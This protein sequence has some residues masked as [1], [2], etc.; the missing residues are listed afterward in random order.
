MTVTT[1]IVVQFS[2]GA[3]GGSLSAEIDS[4]EDGLNLGKSNFLPGDSASFLVFRSPDVT[5]DLV[6][7]SAGTVSSIGS[8]LYEVEEWLTFADSVEV[9]TGKR[10]HSDFSYQWFGKNLGAVTVSGDKVVCPTKGVGVL[11]VSYKAAYE[12]FTLASPAQINGKSE[13][14]I[15]VLVKG[16][17]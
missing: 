10:V 1:S 11:K 7:A 17:N 4:R 15:A 12:A 6:S 14:Q 9:T 8:G 16:H 3:S 2:Q 5:L 13:F